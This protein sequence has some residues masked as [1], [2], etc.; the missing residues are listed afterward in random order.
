MVARR[1]KHERRHAAFLKI[2]VNDYLSHTDNT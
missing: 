1:K 2:T